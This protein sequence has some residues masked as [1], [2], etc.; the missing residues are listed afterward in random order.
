MSPLVLKVQLNSRE[1]SREDYLLLADPKPTASSNEP[2][3]HLHTSQNTITCK[4]DSSDF[5]LCSDLHSDSS[6]VNLPA[7]M[8]TNVSKSTLETSSSSITG[9]SDPWQSTDTLPS[10]LFKGPSVHSI[11][12]TA[13]GDVINHSNGM[14]CS[15]L[16]EVGNAGVD[17]ISSDSAVT[18]NEFEAGG[19][20]RGD[21]AASG[22]L[23]SSDLI[24]D[25]KKTSPKELS[26]CDN[27]LHSQQAKD[28]DRSDSIE[29][30]T[31]NTASINSSKSSRGNN[32]DCSLGSVSQQYEIHHSSS[33]PMLDRNNV[34]N[35]PVTH[36]S[37]HE[38]DPGRK[39]LYLKKKNIYEISRAFSE[40]TKVSNLM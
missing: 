17:E 29:S 2:S 1:N 30:A 20:L 14:G 6:P 28:E 13:N 12:T 23:C 3:D 4:Y 22:L 18:N 26:T 7:P 37:R 36:R 10:C 31:G 8:S 32:S 35:S 5:P 39:P 34:V 25:S 9:T 11:P 33:T 40:P 27:L 19:Q 24:R 15:N 38:S 21:N 16:T